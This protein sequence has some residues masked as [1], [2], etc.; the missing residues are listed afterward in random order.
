ML[1]ELDVNHFALIDDIHLSFGAHLN[2]LTGETGA[3]KSIIVDAMKLLLGDR[4][5]A[6]DIRYGEEMARVEGVFDPSPA[7]QEKLREMDL[8]DDALVLSREVRTGGK[9]T[10][11][12]N[13]R[14]VTLAQFKEIA[15]DLV[16]IYGQHDYQGLARPEHQLA[17]LDALGDDVHQALLAQVRNDYMAAQRTGRQF[18]KLLKSEKAQQEAYDEAARRL[19][20]LEPLKL[21]RGEEERVRKAYAQAHHAEMLREHTAQAYA[22]LYDAEYSAHGQLSRA[23]EALSQA[24]AV[25]ETLAGLLPGLEEAFI[26][27]SEASLDL[28][29]Y[30][31]DTDPER[32]EKL[33]ERLELQ[34]KL[35][36]RFGLSIDDLIDR[37]DVWR[38][39]IQHAGGHSAALS[40][41]KAAY[42]AAK[43]EYANS[44]QRLRV[45]R[46][47]LAERFEKA[48]LMH[49]NDLS[50]PHA[51]FKV[52]FS[53]QNGTAAG[54]DGVVFELSANP[55]VPLAPLH[56]I[57]SGGEMSRI[58]LAFNTILSAHIGTDTLIFD[59]IDTGIGGITLNQVAQKL[60]T[61]AAER[62]VI[63]V[64]HAAPI[65]ALADDHFHIRKKTDGSSTHVCVNHL[66]DEET[67]ME[68]ARMLGGVDRWHLAYARKMKDP[69]SDDEPPSL[70]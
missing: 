58:M 24:A 10:C 21:M 22:A 44:T 31:A 20:E 32:L 23:I 1:Q 52:R 50:M 70:F 30:E 15:L 8:S 35:K 47:A 14:V 11:R 17:M 41:A 25:D 5:S 69:S 68:L 45:S 34:E 3:G 40:D 39:E 7:V 27:V 28:S 4:A 36:R 18:K 6:H 59:E 26:N 66:E 67:I 64:T 53:E 55:G 60:A 62:Q 61:V 9:N 43:E 16:S 38:H 54:I 12:I 48:L 57:A 51:R 42:Q 2:V 49:L 46:K 29:H 33:S 65:A 37:M 63:C 19:Q 13:H 56:D